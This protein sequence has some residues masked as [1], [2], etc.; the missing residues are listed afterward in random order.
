M[1]LIETSL[2]VFI[3]VEIVLILMLSL[4]SLAIYKWGKVAEY[5]E[6]KGM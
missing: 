5:S 3:P 2:H 6:P 1:Q 4:K